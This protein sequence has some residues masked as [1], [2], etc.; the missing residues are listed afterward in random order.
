MFI[1]KGGR[2]YLERKGAIDR[3]FYDNSLSM[4]QK[5]QTAHRTALNTISKVNQSRLFNELQEARDAATMKITI[6]DMRAKKIGKIEKRLLMRV[7]ENMEEGTFSRADAERMVTGRGTDAEYDRL[8]RKSA[9]FFSGGNKSSLESSR[10]LNNRGWTELLPFQTYGSMMTHRLMRHTKQVAGD[11]TAFRQGKPGAW[12]DLAASS[13]NTAKFIGATTAQGALAA[14]IRAAIYGG[15]AMGVSALYNEAKDKT[16]NPLSGVVFV[17]AMFANGLSG[18]LEMATRPIMQTGGDPTR[19]ADQVANAKVADLFYVGQTVKDAVDAFNG[20]NR[21][22]DMDPTERMV[23][24]LKVRAPILRVADTV[25][26]SYGIGNVSPETEG[27]ISAFYKWKRETDPSSGSGGNVKDENRAF[28]TH[29]R[30][31]HAALKAGK[32]PEDISKELGQAINLKDP[33][34]AASSLRGRRILDGYYVSKKTD[35]EKYQK[36]KAMLESLYKRVGPKA[37]KKLMDHD[38]LLTEWANGISG[39]RSESILPFTPPEEKD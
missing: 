2:D 20:N 38:T 35:N 29:M 39:N 37:Y 24:Y 13:V 32:P 4:Q 25:A 19:L 36:N 26:G 23:A 18:P 22:K 6:D 11:I 28:R 12:G 8:L 33:A 16:G 3:A 5:L 7:I 1:A 10:F 34:A 9:S 21:F 27:A 15:G 30:R 14:T 17:G 31:V